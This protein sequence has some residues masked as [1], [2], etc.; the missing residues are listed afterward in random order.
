M[1]ACRLCP[2]LLA[3]LRRNHRPICAA[4]GS[5][6]ASPGKVRYGRVSQPV[7]SQFGSRQLGGHRRARERKR[8]Q[9]LIRLWPSS[10]RAGARRRSIRSAI[11]WNGSLMTV[12]SESA[13]GAGAVRGLRRAGLAA[14]EAR[15]CR[16]RPAVRSISCHWLRR[17]R[18]SRSSPS[19][20]TLQVEFGRV[21]RGE[22]LQL[23]GGHRSSFA[24]GP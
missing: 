14:P 7:S 15:R 10:C 18:G 2:R 16:A 8:P 23:G 5:A 20:Q 17:I 4:P 11:R 9:R 19:Q 21:R 6:A 24:R 13:S 22:R 12:S 3:A 1:P